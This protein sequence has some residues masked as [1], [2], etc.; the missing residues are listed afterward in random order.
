MKPVLLLLL[1][2]LAW[3]APKKPAAPAAAGYELEG[4]GWRV[5]SPAGYKKSGDGTWERSRKAAAVHEFLVAR[6]ER[7]AWA[8]QCSA[9]LQLG[10]VAES[11]HR[12]KPAY[13][14]ACT[15]WSGRRFTQY[16]DVVRAPADFI[17]LSYGASWDAPQAGKSAAQVLPGLEGFR[18]WRATLA[19]VVP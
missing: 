8:A 1:P 17:R 2:V 11:L 16:F 6:I 15:E 12:G 4:S 13:S 3:S 10:P 5:A 7:G 14:Y 9:D 18:A 19:P